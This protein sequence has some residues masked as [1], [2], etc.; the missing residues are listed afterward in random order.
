[1]K[2]TDLYEILAAPINCPNGLI[3]TTFCCAIAVKHTTAM[4]NKIS[5]ANKVNNSYLQTQ[6]IN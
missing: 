2:M 6:E 5:I 3:F 1:M 4:S